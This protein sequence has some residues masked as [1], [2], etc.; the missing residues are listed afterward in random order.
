MDRSDFETVL[1]SIFGVEVTAT[2]TG[3]D[4]RV[5]SLGSATV[6]V[7]SALYG[8]VDALLQACDELEYDETSGVAFLTG[9]NAEFAVEDQTSRPLR[10]R[11]DIVLEN[12][13]EGLRYELGQSS[14]QLALSLGFRL[15]DTPARDRP[16]RAWYYR[17]LRRDDSPLDVQRLLSESLRLVTLKIESSA[18]RTRSEWRSISESFY[19][20]L[21]FN[22]DYALIP[23]QSLGGLTRS[24]R[25]RR[26]RRARPEHLDAPRRSYIPELVRSYQLA[27]SSESPMLSYLSF[28]HVAEHWFEDVFL[29]DVAAR[30]Q[31]A[32]TAP[33]FSAK[34][35]KDLRA[36][37]KTVSKSLRARD[38]AV[39]IN[40]ATAL[41]LTIRK[42]VSVADLVASLDS[43]DQTL[44]AYYRDHKAP[45]SVGNETDLSGGDSDAVVKS[46][47]QRI[48][49]TRN[50]LVHRKDGERGRYTPFT[51]DQAL[52]RELPLL[53]F[54]AEQIVISSSSIL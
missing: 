9:N 15:L 54:I 39:V 31:S 25:I 24:T 49:K 33:G 29:D 36:L 50:T 52:Q 11:D 8:E 46:L 12:H 37:I 30:V 23:L 4:F 3:Y 2:D 48:Y 44:V 20:H 51:D 45:F 41:E 35:K 42:Y 18:K 21:G 5:R 34:R 14:P 13:S 19:F 32:I 22:L 47:A 10:L 17:S 40:E 38:D 26:L 53:R 16:I 28:Y 1:R 7:E 27:L 6:D 43:F